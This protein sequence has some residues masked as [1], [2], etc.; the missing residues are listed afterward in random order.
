MAEHGK[1][2]YQV[3]FIFTTVGASFDGTMMGHCKVEMRVG[4]IQF[5]FKELQPCLQLL[6][7]ESPV[8]H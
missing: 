1:T 2:G 7:S 5:G 3:T 6:A 4:A 8:S